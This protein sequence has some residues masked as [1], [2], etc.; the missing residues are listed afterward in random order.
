MSD[1]KM[2]LRGSQFLEALFK[3]TEEGLYAGATIGADAAVRSFGRQHGGKSSAPGSPPNVQSGF[4][5]NSVTAVNAND[6]GRPLAAAYGTNV[7]YGRYLEFGANVRGRPWL[8]VPIHPDA[9]KAARRGIP[10][11][12]LPLRLI[13]TKT[14]LLLIRDKKGKNARTEVWF[15]L[16][17]AVKIA[18]R[19]W[20]GRSLNDNRVQIS[21]RINDVVSRKMRGIQVIGQ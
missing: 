8:T 10:A 11:R 15:V 21:A 6:L 18:A 14:Q 4:L 5:R 16:K 13:K 3:A 17:R 1:V 19:P 7:P 2:K 9:K 20:L 12:R